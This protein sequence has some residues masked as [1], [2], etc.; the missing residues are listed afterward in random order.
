M[1]FGKTSSDLSCAFYWRGASVRPLYHKGLIGGVLQRW[2]SFRNVLPS[3]QRNSGALSEWPSDYQSPPWPRSF[4]RLL[5]LAGRPAL[6]RLLVVPNVLH[7]RMMEATVFLGTFNAAEMF[8]FPSRNLCLD[9]I[10]SLS[11][12]GNSFDLMTWFLLWHALST[13]GRYIDRSMPF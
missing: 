1:P 8:L 11:S 6:G 9:A 7:L 13:V 3:P 5:S 4:S 2:L 12:T 10:L